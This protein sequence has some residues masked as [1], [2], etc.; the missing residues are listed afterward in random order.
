MKRFVVGN[1]KMNGSIQQIHE[2]NQ[3]SPRH[4]VISVICPPA[5]FIPLF[6]PQHIHVGAQNCHHQLSGAYTGE[7]SAEQLKALGC[8]YVIL[9]HSE[10][11]AQFTESSELVNHKASQAIQAGLIPIICVGE[12]ETERRESRFKHVLSS[13]LDISLS[14][15]NLEQCVIAYEPVWSIGTGL[16]PTTEQITEV[17]ELIRNL[18][19]KT[20]KVL[21]GGSV[22]NKNI[23]TIVDIPALDGVLVGGASLSLQ[24][25]QEIINAFQGE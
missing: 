15:I 4:N 24:S 1:W 8:T 18:K 10:R 11:R 12:T 6:N 13:Q 17:I 14:G 2:F 25:F 23:K 9:G 19:G 16:V 3:L 21:Y 22:N 20:T 5:C 7:V